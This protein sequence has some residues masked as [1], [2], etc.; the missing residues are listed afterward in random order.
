MH[1]LSVHMRWPIFNGF[2]TAIITGMVKGT[3]E[4]E[5]G[6]RHECA[7]VQEGNGAACPAS[8]STVNHAHPL[9]GDRGRGNLRDGVSEGN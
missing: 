3:E 2:L 5:A 7:C 4:F 6:P 9:S 1:G 8:L